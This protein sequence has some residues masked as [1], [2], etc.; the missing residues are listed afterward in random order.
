[1]GRSVERGFEGTI[2]RRRG[3]RR[4]EGVARMVGRKGEEVEGRKKAFV[5]GQK[6]HQ[7]HEEEDGSKSCAKSNGQPV[8]PMTRH[9]VASKQK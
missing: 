6:D 5:P 1:M 7:G 3:R 2:E 8:L 9:I 4:S